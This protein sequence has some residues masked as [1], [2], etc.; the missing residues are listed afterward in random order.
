MFTYNN[1]YETEVFSVNDRFTVKMLFEKI[2]FRYG[3]KPS[4]IFLG[5]RIINEETTNEDL[6]EVFKCYEPTENICSV[7]YFD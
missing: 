4:K 2:T 7:V 5:I 6:Q 3:K 1:S